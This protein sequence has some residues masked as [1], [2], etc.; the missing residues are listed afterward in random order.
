MMRDHLASPMLIAILV[1][2][3]SPGVNAAP[4]VPGGAARLEEVL[5]GAVVPYEGRQRTEV[6]L[7]GGP[8]AAVVQVSSDGQGRTR[9]EFRVGKESG[10]ISL[11]AGRSSWQRGPDKRWIML[12]DTP[13]DLDPAATAASIMR[14]YYVTIGQPQIVAG[15]KALP[16]RIAHKRAHDPS[17]NVWL[18]PA[19]GIVLR[20]VLLAPDNRARSSTE[21][22]DLALKP[23]SPAQFKPPA[24]YTHQSLFGPGSFT[25]RS[26]ASS[27]E[28]ECGRPVLLPAYVP[29]GYR[30]VLHGTMRTGSG[31]LM[32]ALQYSDGLAA[33]TIFQRGRNAGR[34]RG[35]GMA[36]PGHGTG[37]P[38]QTGIAAGATGCIGQSDLQTSIVAV[39]AIRSNYL[40]VGDLSEGELMRVA[41]S[42]P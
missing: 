11:Q 23:Q 25:P 13:R 31:R 18:D 24:S 17:R 36:G 6:F 33:F 3:A 2:A 40:L 26:S 32:P 21:F 34:G 5:R 16:I 27:V 12:P 20:D 14:N 7:A 10:I 15:R 30:L 28:E 37:P 1:A 4:R 8:T 29:E 9:R 39:T 22:I 41:K 35:A 42:L 38:A 19:T